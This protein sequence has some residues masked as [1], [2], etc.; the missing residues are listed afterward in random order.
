MRTEIEVSQ[1]R[2]LCATGLGM[3]EGAVSRRVHALLKLEKTREGIVPEDSRKSQPCSLQTS[4]VQN[5]KGI[6]L[7][8][9]ICS[10]HVG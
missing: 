4:D 3:E 6:N 9:V 5:C 1:E 2:G 7:S 10:A 8:V